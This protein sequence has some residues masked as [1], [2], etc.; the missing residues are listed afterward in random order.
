MIDVHFSGNMCSAHWA[1]CHHAGKE[2]VWDV[3]VPIPLVPEITYR[4]AVVDDT[5]NLIKWEEVIHTIS[6][7]Q[8]LEDGAI[9]D[10][11][12]EW[13]D[14]SHPAHLLSS[15]AFTQVI[16]A[17]K[18]DVVPKVTESIKPTPNESIIRF[19][20]RDWELQG[21]Q[22]MC[23]S[24][25]APQLGNWQLHHVLKMTQTSASCWEAE[26]SVPLNVF[27]VTYKY[28]VE[29]RGGG[30][31]TLEH[32]ESRLVTLPMSE[33]SRSPTMVVQ[34]DG[35]FR[36]E[37]RW[38]GAGVAVPV[39]S[40]RSGKSVGCGEFAD[41]PA[42]VDWCA[43]AG[44]KMLQILPVSDTSVRGTW[45]DSYP[46]SSICVFALHPMYLCISK[47]TDQLPPGVDQEIEAVR[48][49]LDL[50]PDVDYEATMAAKLR[51]SRKIFNA[52]GQ[53][54]L[55]N[56]EFE[57]FAK[58]NEEWLQPYAIFCFLKEFF[59][60]A[61][62]WRWG[63]FSNPTKEALRKLAEPDRE[64]HATVQYHMYLQY[65]L[66]RQLAAASAYAG[67]SGVAL[68]GDLPIGVDKR[69]VDTW[70]A[71]RQ[72]RMDASTG[73][74]PDYFDANGQNWGFPTYNWEEMEADG[75]SWWRRRLAHMEQY[76][77]AYRIDHILGF[78]RIWELPSDTKL[79]L[80]G[81]FRPSVPLYRHELESRGIWDF[82][83]LCEPYITPA[84]LDRTFGALASEIADRYFVE[85]S[86]RRLKFRD[87]YASEK[88]LDKLRARAGLPEELV[89]EMEVTRKGLLALRQNVVLLRDPDDPQQRFYPVSS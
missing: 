61:E 27:P 9:V 14:S 7:P 55:Q 46:Y 56:P 35:Y 38:R 57:S 25:A 87:Q 86:G 8:G 4:Y 77:H 64:W 5:L 22:E 36:R 33:S 2:L 30:G 74:P 11:H 63:A 20:V 69:S 73:A 68:K 81:R 28:G 88:A 31:L 39:F 58:A 52:T 71:P 21:N 48:A 60:T 16:L 79:G 54:T 17:D 76:F 3:I 80:L 6:L 50:L 18:P 53:Q 42:M 49:K 34:N 26:V 1:T 70:L 15:C 32:G 72:F 62:Y 84:L 85:G 78:F 23:V 51:I 40:L 75:Y 19:Q 67:A 37:R 83:R 29:E 10:I 66:H 45:Q 12:D 47:L 44:L 41:L 65:H 13:M 82:D 24:G 59:G 43:S 89:N